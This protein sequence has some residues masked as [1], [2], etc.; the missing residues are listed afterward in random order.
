MMLRHTLY[1]TPRDATRR[2]LPLM[3]MLT[4]F[5]AMAT[6]IE[7]AMIRYAVDY[8]RRHSVAAAML[9]YFLDDYCVCRRHCRCACRAA[10][11][12][13]HATLPIALI[14]SPPL[15]CCRRCHDVAADDA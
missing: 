5:D 9:R 11:R 2:L 1:V 4:V 10:F 8:C 15:R 12:C 6:L 14:F 3:L 13:R 7:V